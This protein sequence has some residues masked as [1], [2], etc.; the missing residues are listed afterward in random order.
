M[1]YIEQNFEIIVGNFLVFF[2]LGLDV[3]ALQMADYSPLKWRI[4][5]LESLN[6]LLQIFKFSFYTVHAFPT[7]FYVFLFSIFSF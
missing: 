6:K 4:M 2:S 1:K 5:S 7:S 3:R